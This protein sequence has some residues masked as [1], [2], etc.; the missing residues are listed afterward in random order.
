VEQGNC[1]SCVDV[2]ETVDDKGS[3]ER[4]RAG[5]WITAGEL[6]ASRGAHDLC[7]GNALQEGTQERLRHETRPWNASVLG[8][9]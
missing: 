7:E 9:R 2:G 6:V 5:W 3:P 8:N 4:G 1:V